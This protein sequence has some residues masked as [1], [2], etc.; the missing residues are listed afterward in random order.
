MILSAIKDGNNIYEVTV[1]ANDGFTGTTDRVFH[2]TLNRLN[3][4]SPVIDNDSLD[5]VQTT[6]PVNPPLVIRYNE[7]QSIATIVTTAIATDGDRKPGSTPTTFVPADIFEYTLTGDDANLFNIDKLSGALTFKAI[8][9]FESPIDKDKNNSYELILN[10][11]DG[12]SGHT[13]LRPFTVQVRPINDNPII[14]SNGGAGDGF[15]QPE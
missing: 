11:N 9:D 13:Q 14:T 8:P 4:L 10:V 7:E 3:D 15:D 12:D 5:N 2:V 1:R 6:P